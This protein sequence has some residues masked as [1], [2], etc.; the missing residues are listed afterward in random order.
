MNDH[1]I[2]S[3]KLTYDIKYLENLSPWKVF[4][5]KAKFHSLFKIFSWSDIVNLFLRLLVMNE[6]WKA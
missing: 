4:E 2:Y 5:R 1:Y 6:F 3:R